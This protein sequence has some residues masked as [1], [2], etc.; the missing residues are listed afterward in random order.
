MGRAVAL[1][2]RT[3]GYSIGNSGGFLAVGFMAY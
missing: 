1:A 2:G 3:S